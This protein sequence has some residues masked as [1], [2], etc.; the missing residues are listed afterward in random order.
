MKSQRSLKAGAETQK[1]TVGTEITS[2]IV[3]KG[4]MR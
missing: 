3:N 2:K 4:L 1:L